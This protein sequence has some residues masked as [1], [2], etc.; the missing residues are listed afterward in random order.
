MIVSEQF[1]TNETLRFEIDLGRGQMMR[2][3]LDSPPEG[4]DLAVEM[5]TT[6][7]P[8][9]WEPAL[10]SL[11]FQVREEAKLC[12]FAMLA[13]SKDWKAARAEIA[14]SAMT[15]SLK[16]THIVGKGRPRKWREDIFDQAEAGKSL[17]EAAAAIGIS[18]RRIQKILEVHGTNYSKLKRRTKKKSIFV[19]SII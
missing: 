14:K 10:R 9:L 16:R 18:E 1:I 3:E 4:G 2:V 12:F 19:R 15:E 13:R 5:M 11:Y 7:F 17:A 8:E 6:R